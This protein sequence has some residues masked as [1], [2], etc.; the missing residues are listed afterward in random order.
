MTRLALL[1]AAL[2]I[3][4][5]AAV[6]SVVRS[7]DR[8]VRS[9]QEIFA[10]RCAYCHEA[11]GW[12]TRVLARRVPEGQAELRKRTNLPPALTRLAVRRGIGAM[13]QFT[14]PEL[15]DEELR[16]LADWL[17]AGTASQR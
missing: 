8:P 16:A 4:L 10:S 14:P 2:A 13:P 17:A 3:P 12:G 5:G 15:S 11:G 6:P 1:V 7:S 9:P